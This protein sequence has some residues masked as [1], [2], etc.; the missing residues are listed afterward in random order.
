MISSTLIEAIH[1][2]PN[3]MPNIISSAPATF[4]T[5]AALSTQY[6]VWGKYYSLNLAG[7]QHPMRSHLELFSHDLSVEHAT[8]A[9]PDA[10]ALMMNPGG[11]QPLPS[12]CLING[13]APAKPDTTQYQLMRI[14]QRVGWQ[15]V[16][17]LNLSDFRAPKSADFVRFL[18]QH[19]QD[20]RHSIFSET[21]AVELAA[22]LGNTQG[23]ILGWGVAPA[24]EPLARLVLAALPASIHRFGLK[25]EV[26]KP[27]T[28]WIYKHPLP[29][30]QPAGQRAWVETVA[31]QIQCLDSAY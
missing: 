28:D 19:P 27:K 24:F 7:N 29:L 5:A 14:M 20:M 9:T 25:G 2:A 22:S 17:V 15:H 1:I 4:A 31:A 21:R 12:M 11:S 6:A 30:A 3:V 26:N 18:A 16:R 8:A 23:V 10:V 13:Y